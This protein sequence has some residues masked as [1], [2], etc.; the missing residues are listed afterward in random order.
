[1]KKLLALLLSLVLI[2]T[3]SACNSGNNSDSSSKDKSSSSSQ[4][5]VNNQNP[6]PDNLFEYTFTDADYDKYITS[7]NNL[8]TSAISGN[9][10]DDVIKYRDESENLSNYLS[11]QNQIAN[12]I[13]YAENTEEASNHYEKIEKLL[14]QA[15]AEYYRIYRDI[16]TSNSAFKDIVFEGWTTEEIRSLANLDV[17][18]FIRTRDALSDIL[19]E[20]NAL[21]DSKS[22]WASTV[23]SLYYEHV[24]EANN[25]AK[26]WG[27]S[28][29]Y[30][31]MSENGYSRDYSA[32]DRQN[33]RK[34]VKE[35]IVPAYD[36]CYSAIRR[37]TI[38]QT[39][40]NEFNRISNTAY[41]KL[42]T[43][44]VKGF[45]STFD[46][47]IKQKMEAMFD[48]KHIRFG[49]KDSL[50]AAFTAYLPYYDQSVVFLSDGYYK[51][52]STTVHEM[53]H[54]VSLYNYDY[55]ATSYDLLETHSQG[56]E[57]LLLY[58]LKDHMSKGA[59]KI[60][61]VDEI[62]TLY[63]L[64]IRCAIID[65]FEETVYKA[66]IPYQPSEYDDLIERICQKYGSNVNQSLGIDNYLKHVIIRSPVY[67]I[68]YAT[69]AISAANFYVKALDEGYEAAQESYRKLQEGNKD[70][71]FL[72]NLE[73]AGLP[74]PFK[75][76]TYVN[77]CNKFSTLY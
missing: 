39:D 68:S 14:T 47:S 15:A 12:V 18:E 46:G 36:E 33:F 23:N 71:G 70:E 65:E 1:M 4:G 29:Y 48:G 27:Y 28:N 49:T 5:S 16:Y 20:F 59:Y 76:E 13:Y 61:V 64:M 34:Y 7:L 24:T 3:F 31:Y 11:T 50:E 58:Y 21:D 57:W 38:T 25:Q 74:S 40:L 8:K 54:F 72:Y 66:L 60:K 42:E 19:L 56:S 41:D 45:I 52:T 43:D 30:D 37:L 26:A 51:S 6:I 17:N 44:Y 67:Y 32:S 62:A 75:S 22:N 55:S 69:S 53:G 9:S 2:F 35:Y 77:L 73:Y 10:K 63:D